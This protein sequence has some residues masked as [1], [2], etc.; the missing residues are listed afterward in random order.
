MVY[1]H[2]GRLFINIIDNFF[3]RPRELRRAVKY[4]LSS[5]Y[6]SKLGIMKNP[7]K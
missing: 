4:T 6:K 1:I 3:K 2:A 7:V 5:E